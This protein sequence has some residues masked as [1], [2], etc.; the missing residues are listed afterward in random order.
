[1]SYF[2]PASLEEAT[3]L[4]AEK[5][6]SVIA[7][8]TDIFPA[9]GDV[10]NG[11]LMLDISG[12]EGL[13]GLSKTSQGWRI[14]AMTTWTDV[15]RAKLP[16]A[17]DGLKAAAASVG[18]L[19]VQN[20]GTVGGNLCNA[21]P[22]ADGVPALLVLDASVELASSRGSRTLPLSKFITG[23]RETAL[24]SDEVLTAIHVP[25]P[26]VGAKGG[27]CKHGNRAHLIISTAMAASL[28]WLDDQGKVAGARVA[29]GACSPVA[30]RLSALEADV[31][32]ISA[33]D[34]AQV[35]VSPD[36]L[37]L[38]SPISDIRGSAEY[39]LELAGVLCRRALVLAAT[40]SGGPWIDPYQT[41]VCP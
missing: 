28:V 40:G 27:F 38:L 1:M 10:R 13:R 5:P 33:G 14:G 23:V 21:S 16:A 6:V 12:I 25:D 8:G 30:Q 22:A 39:R 31:A 20:A 4:L 19:Q 3:R 7:G 17:F 35:T 37:F 9:M 11:A 36:H 29:V 26:P 24:A 34:L 32:G 15:Y 18:A 41:C 2:M